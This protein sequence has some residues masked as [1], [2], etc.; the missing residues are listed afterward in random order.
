MYRAS[1]NN[2]FVEPT[3]LALNAFFIH[4]QFSNMF[5]YTICHHKRVF[6]VIITLSNDWLC[7]KWIN[8][9]R[10]TCT[11]V[12]NSLFGYHPILLNCWSMWRIMISWHIWS[13]TN[14]TRKQQSA[15]TVTLIIRLYLGLVWKCKMTAWRSREFHLSILVW[16]PVSVAA[17]SKA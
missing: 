3:L 15:V 11:H 8:S 17:R 1:Y 9:Q 6:I 4:Y 13:S 10:Y 16:W 2:S 12:C 7:D 5:R 14:V